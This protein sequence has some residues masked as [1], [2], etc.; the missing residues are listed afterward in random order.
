MYEIRHIFFS[1]SKVMTSDPSPHKAFL[2]IGVCITFRVKQL[3]MGRIVFLG[4]S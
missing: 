2:L 3:K 1:L 4:S